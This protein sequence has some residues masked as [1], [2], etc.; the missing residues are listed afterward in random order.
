MLQTFEHGYALL[1]GVG[2]CQHTPFSLPVTV[3]DVSE[4]RSVLTDPNHGAYP[5]DEDH[6]RLLHDEGATG[7]AV[8]DGLAWLSQC[9]AADPAATAVVYYSGHGYLHERSDRYFLITHESDPADLEKTA[10]AADKFNQALAAVK[11]K[12]LLVLMDCCHAEGMAT[13]RAVRLIQPPAGFIAAALPEPMAAA[14]QQGEG[15]A[16]LSSSRGTQL[17]WSRADGSMGYFTYHLVEA[18]RGAAGKPED[19]VV[20]VADLMDFLNRH[21]PESVQSDWQAEQTPFFNIVAENLPWRCAAAARPIRPGSTR[22][23]SK[24]I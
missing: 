6:V 11:A 18:L 4:I 9:A 24:P 12:R 15:R 3:K 23:W 21:V 8:L 22:R 14:L 10:L 17:S 16:V 5:D 13:A 20:R 7:K 1:I 19:T 2:Q